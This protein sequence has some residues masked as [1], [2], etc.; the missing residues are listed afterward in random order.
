M[1][2]VKSFLLLKF[3]EGEEGVGRLG[4]EG[5]IIV[6]GLLL[7]FSGDG[8]DEFLLLLLELLLLVDDLRVVGRF[9]ELGLSHKR[10]TRV[11]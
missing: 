7:W 2:S 5:D 4:H 1:L 6:F 3:E 11:V 9:N 8:L 10:Y